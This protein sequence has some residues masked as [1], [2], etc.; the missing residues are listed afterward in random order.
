M[1]MSHVRFSFVQLLKVFEEVL[2]E[3]THARAHSPQY[4]ARRRGRE[5]T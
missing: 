1:N 3:Y 2:A 5:R 4:R